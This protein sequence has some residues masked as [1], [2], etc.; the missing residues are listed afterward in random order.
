MGSR[1]SAGNHRPSRRLIEWLE[2]LSYHRQTIVLV[3]LFLALLKLQRFLYN[4]RGFGKDWEPERLHGSNEKKSNTNFM[5]SPSS[6]KSEGFDAILDFV[7]REASGH[8]F[9]S[10][11]IPDVNKT[12]QVPMPMGLGVRNRIR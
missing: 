2:F 4:T 7:L 8:V 6:L 1:L 5:G 10:Q 3:L 12:F 11:K 9:G